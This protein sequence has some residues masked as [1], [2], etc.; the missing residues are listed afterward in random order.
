M[1]GNFQMKRRKI[2]GRNEAFEGGFFALSI[3]EEALWGTK[4]E[5]DK[6]ATLKKE[7][8]DNVSCWNHHS[9]LNCNLLLYS[10]SLIPLKTVSSRLTVRTTGTIPQVVMTKTGF[11]LCLVL[12][13]AYLSVCSTFTG[14]KGK[15]R[16]T[17]YLIRFQPYP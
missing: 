8:N 5:V 7:E 11:S 4:E 3:G 9:N 12:D 15:F 16:A 2:A 17:C 14:E 1:D 13:T 6:F 10:V